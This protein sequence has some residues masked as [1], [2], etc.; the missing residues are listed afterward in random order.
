MVR[1]VFRLAKE[2]APAIIF[3]D[4][5]DAIATKR[6]D[7]Q[8][9]GEWYPHRAWGL[10]QPCLWDAVGW[11]CYILSSWQG[12]S[13]NPAG[14]TESNGW[15]W[16][17]RQRQGLGFRMGRGGVVWESGKDGGWPMRGQ[18]LQWEGEYRRDRGLSWPVPDARWSWPQT[19]QTPWILPCCGR[20]AL[21]VKLNF[22]SLTAVRR[23]WFSLLSPARWISL[24]RLTWK[25][26]SSSRSKGRS[27]LGR[28]V[29]SPPL[30]SPPPRLSRWETKVW[31][32]GW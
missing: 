17:E 32:R 28:G 5:I 25:I 4:E 23:D 24:R 21:T 11:P 12:G 22:H 14:A 19:E 15:I 30:P 8:T 6:F 9:G 31:G 20:D 16:P 29:V 7:A 1:D 26:V 10:G 18:L 13:E 27:P 2:N 3:I